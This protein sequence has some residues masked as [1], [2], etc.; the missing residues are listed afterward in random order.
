MNNIDHKIEQM[1]LDY[2]EVPNEFDKKVEDTLNN[3]TLLNTNENSFKR[4]I[5]NNILKKIYKFLGIGVLVTSAVSVCAYT[6]NKVYNTYF[7][8]QSKIEEAENNNIDYTNEDFLNSGVYYKKIDNY[9]EYQLASNDWNNLI[10]MSR[11][12]FNDNVLIVISIFD[13]G[14]DNLFV[15]QIDCDEATTYVRLKKAP[16]TNTLQEN[17]FSDPYQLESSKLSVKIPKNQIKDNIKIDIL[18]G[19]G[20]APE[21][22]TP[23]E[24]IDLVYKDNQA[25]LE[26]CIVV[27]KGKFISNNKDKLFKFANNK[28]ENSFIRVIEYGNLISPKSDTVDE[29]IIGV[30][31]ILY[32]NNKYYV[33]EF[34]YSENKEFENPSSFWIGDVFKISTRTAFVEIYP[35]TIN[36]ITITGEVVHI[37]SFW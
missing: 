1:L 34:T 13:Y 31:D 8:E 37:C 3:I 35:K 11:E 10:K 24:E 23:L 16:Q 21:N 33:D 26:D 28:E 29:N 36:G 12:E 20:I 5:I 32:K 25:F 4:N 6:G 27:Y 17:E 18:P 14:R 7:K 19:S 22:Y 15:Q 30:R 9:E 2:L